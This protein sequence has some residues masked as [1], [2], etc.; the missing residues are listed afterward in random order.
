M[1]AADKIRKYCSY[2]DR[3]M[4]EVRRKMA[5]L[6]IPEEEA[7]LLME[8]LIAEHY[9]DDAR[10]AESFIRGKMNIKRWGRV[11]IRAEL[12]MRGISAEV[13]N[14]K[15]SEIDVD[16]YHANLRYLIQKWENE[17]PGGE[18]DK[19]IR[20]LMGKGYEYAEIAAAMQNHHQQ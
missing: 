7:E 5:E 13:M 15:I 11:K 4:R 10:F 6:L 20:F 19:L 12:A 18:R 3:S 2:Q 14:E 8:E 1:T 17:H 9:V 16:A